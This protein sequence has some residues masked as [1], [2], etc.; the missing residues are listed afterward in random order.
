MIAAKK[1]VFTEKN[2]SLLS[3]K[4]YNESYKKLEYITKHSLK[5]QENEIKSKINTLQEYI[6]L[7][8]ELNSMMS[9][10]ASWNEDLINLDKKVAHK[11]IYK[12]IELFPSSF[13]NELSTII[14]DILKS[15]NLPKYETARFNLKSFDIEINNDQKN[16]NGKGFT[17]FYN[18]VLVLAFRKYLYDKA[19]IKPFFFIIDTPL[20]GLD[21][22][23]AEF[24]NNNIRTGIYQYFINSIEQGQLIIF[25]NEKDMPKINFT[26]KKIKTIYFSHIKD[27]TT[28][29]GFLLDYED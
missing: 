7:T 10:T 18:T 25:D 17:A 16:A 12:P 14:K 6:K 23:Q 26:N 4:K 11:T 1:D 3:I 9:I 28:R 24:S 5:K 27:N 2:N 19:N 21:V 8:S 22:G 29:Y 15:C 20:L 13:E